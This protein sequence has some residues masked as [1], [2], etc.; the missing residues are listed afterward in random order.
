VPYLLSLSRLR[1][2]AALL[3]LVFASSACV[4]TGG[5]DKRPD[6]IIGSYVLNGVDPTG[7]AYAG[8]LTIEQA[9]GPDE[10][11][12]QWIVSGVQTGVGTLEGDTLDVAWTTVD[13]VDVEAR[14]RAVFTVQPDGS[15]IGTR[16]VA[17]LDTA[18][19]EEAFPNDD[20]T[21]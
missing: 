14:G 6:S 20:L 17:G 4:L 16:T 12:L 13:G 11:R 3:A 21:R 9:D 10:Y 2:L 15:L 1:L 8:H 5:H 18:G 7:T 19:T